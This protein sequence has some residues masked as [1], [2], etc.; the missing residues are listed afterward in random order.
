MTKQLS[1]RQLI[2]E[3]ARRSSASA[4]QL[5]RGI[6]DDC[7]V[8]GSP[9]NGRWLISTDTLV[10]GVHF[11]RSY[12]EPFVLGRKCVAVNLSDI[13]AMGG[14]PAFVLF[15]LTLPPSLP[16]EWVLQWVEG[17]SAILQ[18]YNCQLIGGDTV[19]GRELSFSITVLGE[20]SAGG[21]VYRDGAAVDDIIYVSGTLGAAAA[22][23]ALLQ[24]AKT[25]QQLKNE[26]PRWPMETG[27][28]LNPTP[29]VELGSLLV[30]HGLVSA[31]QDIS[32]GLAT[33]LAHICSA[34]GVGATIMA[35]KLPCAPSTGSLC[36]HMSLDKTD[37]LLKGGED[38]QLLFTVPADR[39]QDLLALQQN[40]AAFVLTP[41]GTITAHPGV[42]LVTPGNEIVDIS[43]QGYEH[44]R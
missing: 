25:D 23:L 26:I 10:D 2:E 34:S 33:D 44:L 1:E 15:S 29:Q 8:F 12:H 38:Y 21:I 27:A 6:G 35:E 20:P 32:D 24:G 17:A 14:T 40:T 18:Q 19:T 16:S 28:H 41:V 42:R 22:G 7:A 9:D 11:D 5:I 37:T 30:E 4:S 3:I 13:A 39:Q 36:E 43:Y 31:M